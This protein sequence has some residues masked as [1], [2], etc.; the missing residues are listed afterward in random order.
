V[1]KTV[2][3]HRPQP[4]ISRRADPQEVRNTRAITCA[5]HHRL[6]CKKRT[7]QPSWRLAPHVRTEEAVKAISITAPGG[8]DVPRVVQRVDPRPESDEVTIDVAYA[9]VGLVDT[10]F[11]RGFLPI[12]LPIVPGIE[13]SGHVREVGANVKSLKGGQPVAAFLNDFVNLPGCG[14]YAEICRARRP[15]DSVATGL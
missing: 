12:Q 4:A 6:V 5:R 8:P 7:P 1:Q 11:R 13:V 3:P 9:G 2:A 10:L 15:H 14:G